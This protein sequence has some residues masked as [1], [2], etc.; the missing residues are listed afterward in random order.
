M[1]RDKE[2]SKIKILDEEVRCIPEF[3]F[4]E[5]NGS[6]FFYSRQMKQ[7][8]KTRLLKQ[9]YKTQLKQTKIHESVV[10]YTTRTE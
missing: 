9:K 10:Q 7:Q 5:K 8:D 6:Y 4:S 2:N 1:I 3:F